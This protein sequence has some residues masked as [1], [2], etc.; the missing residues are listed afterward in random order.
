MQQLRS[1]GQEP[2]REV[3]R[4]REVGLHDLLAVCCR[5]GVQRARRGAE[6]I[7]NPLPTRPVVAMW[8]LAP[9]LGAAVY[10]E[11]RID[12]FFRRAAEAEAGRGV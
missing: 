7:V 5:S 9:R 1:R 4:R 6:Q 11:A 8:A 12:E 2:P 3:D 10:R